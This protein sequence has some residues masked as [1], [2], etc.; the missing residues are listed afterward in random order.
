MRERIFQKLTLVSIALGTL[1]FAPV[2]GF[3]TAIP[4]TDG[5]ILQIANLG[6]SL[7]GVTTSPTTCINWGGGTT[8][9]AGTTH[10]MGVSGSS[11]DFLFPSTGTIKDLPSFPPPTLADFETVTGGTS[12]GGA[13]VNFD[14]TAVPLS[15]GGAGFGNCGVNTPDNLCSPAGS[16]FTFQMDS[17]GTQLTISFSTLLNAYTGSSTTGVT[18]YRAVFVTQQSGTFIGSGACSGLAVSITNALSCEAGGGTIDATWSATESPTTATP[19]PLS[20]LL[21]GSGLVGLALVR[22]PRRS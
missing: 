14:L 9:T 4:I 15:N 6:G 10:N 13:T 8:C 2:N 19:E 20:L 21:L 11:T 22:R 17:T 3:A 16:P 12:V 7:V 1:A 5:G 18:A